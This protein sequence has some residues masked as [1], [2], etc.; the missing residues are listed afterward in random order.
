M[1]QIWDIFQNQILGM[2]WLN[3]LI[4]NGLKVAGI[5][6]REKLVQ[7]FNFSFTIR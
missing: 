4:G 1:K 6:I 2:Q 5:D 7:V 3:E